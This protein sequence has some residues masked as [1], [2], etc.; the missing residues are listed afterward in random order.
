VVHA[1]GLEGGYVR[2]PP[3]S[4]H[5]VRVLALDSGTVELLAAHRSRCKARARGW[6]GELAEVSYVFSADDAGRRPIR[7]D[8]MTRR[9]GKLAAR[10]GQRSTLYG[11]R[12][13][14]ATQLGA[15]V[16]TGTVR[17]RMGH[18]SLA[19][20]SIYTH[21]VADADRAAAR[22]MGDLVDR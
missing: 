20:T 5:S 9:Y 19:V 6:G 12:H 11:L 22:H 14:M 4:V 18:G 8:A 1:E 16:E 2:K 7:R 3:K 10:L 15:V 21:R 17:G 13:F